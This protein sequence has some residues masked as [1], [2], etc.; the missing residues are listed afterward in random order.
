MK[1]QIVIL[2][3]NCWN[4]YTKK[5]LES[6]KTKY[7]YRI[8]F[9]DNG[10]VD[11]TKDEAGKLVSEKFSHHR[12][13]DNWGTCRSWNFGI[14]DGFTRGAEYVL[15]LN[16]DIILHPD[17]ID[18][19]IERFD[20]KE[21]NLAMITMMDVR[22]EC[23]VPENIFNLKSQDKEITFES[24]H[25][26]FS[27]F[28]INKLCWDKVGKFDEGFFPAYFEDNDWHYRI[29]LLG[30]KA[31]TLP[32]AM[33]YHYGSGTQNADKGNPLVKGIQFDRN[34]DYYAKKWGGTPEAEKYIKPFNI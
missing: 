34:R 22:G 18:R 1:I 28:M 32:T 19:I 20:K 9:I 29:K 14:E 4:R 16:N 8:L 13:E 11:E 30:F 33:F 24:E 26:N 12:N 7:D 5:A 6:I 27:A 17:S 25:P 10:S 31:I 21:E 3:V 23:V 15:V 2:G